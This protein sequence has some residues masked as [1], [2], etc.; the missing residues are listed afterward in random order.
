[1]ENSLP[2]AGTTGRWIFKGLTAPERTDMKPFVPLLCAALAA[3][4][5]SG[6]GSGGAAHPDLVVY[7]DST[8][9]IYTITLSTSTQSQ[10]VSAPQDLGLLERGESYGISLEGE[11]GP[12]TLELKGERGDLLARCRS[13]FEGKRLALTFEE[14]GRVSVSRDE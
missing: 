1:M 14:D 7:N 13:S 10:S 8:R 5:L 4:S 9:V 2:P 11:S 3:L 6:C 12:F